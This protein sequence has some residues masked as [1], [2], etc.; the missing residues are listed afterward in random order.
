MTVPELIAHYEHELKTKRLSMW[1]K[2]IMI[3]TLQFIKA[4]SRKPERFCPH[5]GEKI[6]L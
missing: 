3:Q 2:Q 1:E 6:G 5:C 4:N